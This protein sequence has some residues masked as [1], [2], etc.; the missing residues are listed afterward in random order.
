MQRHFCNR[1]EALAEVTAVRIMAAK[2]RAAKPGFVSQPD[3]RAS[4][5]KWFSERLE[6]PR[7]PLKPHAGYGREETA[8]QQ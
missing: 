5:L 2:Q 1:G 4:R 8:I 7:T 3:N 6:K